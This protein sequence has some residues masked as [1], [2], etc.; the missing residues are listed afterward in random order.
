MDV[1]VIVF[2]GSTCE[3]DLLQ[4]L[5]ILPGVRALAVPHRLPQLPPLDAVALPGGFSHGDYLRP[6]A[7]ARFAP[8]MEAVT[9]FARSGGPVLG[10]CNGFQILTEAGLL[11]GA[12]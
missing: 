9:G 5:S 2:P 4:V 10:I 1:G 7:I 8:V 11:P 3:R 6:G 12:L